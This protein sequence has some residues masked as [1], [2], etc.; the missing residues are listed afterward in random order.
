MSV[1]FRHYVFVLFQA[2]LFTQLDGIRSSYIPIRIFKY[3]VVI[4][5]EY[6]L[7]YWKSLFVWALVYAVC[8]YMSMC[9][10]LCVPMYAYMC[11]GMYMGVSYMHVCLCH[12]CMCLRVCIHV[13]ICV[14]Y[15]CVHLCMCM[16]VPVPWILLSPC[17]SS[18]LW[19]HLC[20]YH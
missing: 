4:I 3:S 19:G 6:I 10:C 2:L 12:V 5:K 15:Y 9:L 7:K 13:F 11:V 1:L 16:H 20:Q 17:I 18:K 14:S 8:V